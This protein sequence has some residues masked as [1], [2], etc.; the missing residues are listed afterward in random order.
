MP[1]MSKVEKLKSAVAQAT[2]FLEFVDAN[3]ERSDT[4]HL[5]EGEPEEA[6]VYGG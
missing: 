3:P 2:M 1:E 5:W 4:S 6:V